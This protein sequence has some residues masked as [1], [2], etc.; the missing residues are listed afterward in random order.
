MTSTCTAFVLL[1]NHLFRSSTPIISLFPSIG[2]KSPMD[3]TGS[4]NAQRAVNRFLRSLCIRSSEGLRSFPFDPLLI[5]AHN[6]SIFRCTRK[7]SKFFNIAKMQWKR[8]LTLRPTTIH[9]LSIRLPSLP[10]LSWIRKSLNK[11][12]SQST[13]IRWFLISWCLAL[14]FKINN[15]F[16]LNPSFVLTRFLNS[17]KPSS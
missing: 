17:L 16:F 1:L 2:M 13:F 6:S 11:L 5:S 15:R 4:K 12:Q 3:C 10:R 14:S 8:R 7:N 9:L